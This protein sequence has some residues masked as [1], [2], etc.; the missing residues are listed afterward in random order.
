[1]FS[2]G[3]HQMSHAS[4]RG[5]ASYTRGWRHPYTREMNLNVR[6]GSYGASST[7]MARP[8]D[9]IS[10]IVNGALFMVRD[11]PESS[12]FEHVVYFRRNILYTHD[13]DDRELTVED[14]GFEG[15][16]TLYV[17]SYDEEGN[18]WSF[19]TFTGW[20]LGSGRQSYLARPRADPGP[21]VYY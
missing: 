15:N 9:R 8:Q 6:I 1:M 5:S 19:N 17:K 7:L 3:S 18:L 12:D 4:S 13:E 14:Y 21:Y 11:L 2:S 10:T 20:E 16:E